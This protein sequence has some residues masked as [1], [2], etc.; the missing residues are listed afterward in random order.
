MKTGVTAKIHGIDAAVRAMGRLEYNA[1]RRV[2]SGA[3]TAGLK[4]LR[5][6]ARAL[7]PVASGGL[8]ASLR[9]SKKLDRKTGTVMGEVKGGK[10]TKTMKRKGQTGFYLR[11]VHEGTKP[12]VIPKQRARNSLS[13]KPKRLSIPGLGVYSRV[14]H[15]GNKANR[16]LLR[17]MDNG[18][19]RAIEAFRKA[20]GEKLEKEAVKK[21]QQA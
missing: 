1:R 20:F 16:F 14:Q 17:A 12:H 18:A 10:A 4:V 11:F 8:K 9:S 2:A 19:S 15:P 3:V 7:A 6:E 5:T 13:A 21:W